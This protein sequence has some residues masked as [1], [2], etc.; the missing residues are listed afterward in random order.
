MRFQAAAASY[1][2]EESVKLESPFTAQAFQAE[3]EETIIIIIMII[4]QTVKSSVVRISG[5]FVISVQK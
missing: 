1:K 5:E 4:M 2:I 3:K